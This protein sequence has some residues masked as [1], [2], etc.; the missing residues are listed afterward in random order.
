MKKLISMILVLTLVL[1]YAPSGIF[2]KDAKAESGT[3]VIN[4][5]DDTWA[6]YSTEYRNVI[7]GVKMD[8]E[9]TNIYNRLY[10]IGASSDGDL[11]T[12]VYN[13]SPV[14]M[15]YDL[16]DF[17]DVKI[18]SAKLKLYGRSL[19][20]TA[21][22]NLKMYF[23]KIDNNWSEN[24]LIHGKTPLSPLKGGVPNIDLTGSGD[25]SRIQPDYVSPAFNMAASSDG[26]EL[27]EFDVTELLKKYNL[28]EDTT[29]SFAYIVYPTSY[30]FE[31]VSKDAEETDMHPAL[32]ITTEPIP[33]FEAVSGPEGEIEFDT[34][35]SVSFTNNIDVSSVDASKIQ[36]FEDGEH[37]EVNEEEISAEDDVLTLSTPLNGYCD[38]TIVIDG[39]CDIYG[40][41][42]AS[43]AEFNFSTVGVHTETVYTHNEADSGTEPGILNGAFLRSGTSNLDKTRVTETS[44]VQIMAGGSA[45]YIYCVEV[46][47]TTVDT[48]V[49][50]ASFVYSVKFSTGA[51]Q[52]INV[53][54]FPEFDPETVTYG[55]ISEAINTGEII[56]SNQDLGDCSSGKY[57][58]F[59]L[60]EYV[61][62]KIEDGDKKIYFAIRP[63]VKHT[64][65]FYSNFASSIHRPKAKI[66]FNDDS[67]TGVKETSPAHAETGV[68]ADSQLN[69]TFS[70]PMES[71]TYENFTL[72]NLSDSSVITLGADDVVYDEATQTATVTPPE[73]LD[74][75][76][77]YELSVFG[78]K[79]LK[80]EMMKSKKIKFIT[81]TSLDTGGISFVGDDTID[82]GATVSAS[83]EL[84]N[85]TLSSVKSPTLILALYKGAMMVD[86]EAKTFDEPISPESSQTLDAS[87]NVPKDSDGYD[88]YFAKA[89][90]WDSAEGQRILKEAAIGASAS[91]DYEKGKFFGVASV[92]GGFAN[93]AEKEISVVAKDKD[94]KICF[95]D[96]ITA[97]E[98]GNYNAE[99]GFEK[100]G[101]YE[102]YTMSESAFEKAPATE[103]SDYTSYADYLDI[104]ENINSENKIKIK[105][106]LTK[107][108]D[109]FDFDEINYN[110]EHIADLIAEDIKEYGDFGS[111]CEENI[112]GFYDF[113]KESSFR[114]FKVSEIL[115]DIAD[116]E[117]Y[118]LLTD[119]LTDRENAEYLQINKYMSKYRDN[120][121]KVNKA[122]AGKKFDTLEDFVEAF[123][124]ALSEKDKD[125]EGGASVNKGNS[126]SGMVYTGTTVTEPQQETVPSADTSSQL[127]QT[128]E[129][130][131]LD[132]SSVPWA[133]KEIEFL[134]R[135]GVIS[136]RGE[137]MYA[138]NDNVLREEYVKLIVETV[139]ANTDNVNSIFEDVKKDSWCYP[140]ISA[141]YANKIVNGI[142]DTKFGVGTPITRQDICVMTARTL[143]LVGFT[144]KAEKAASF[145][146][147]NFVSDYAKS[148]VE[149]LSELGIITGTP[150]GKF[151][152]KAN[153]TRAETALIIF[154]TMD[155]IKTN[156]A[157]LYK[158]DTPNTTES[159]TDKEYKYTT[160]TTEQ[161]K[162]DIENV[163]MKKSHPYIHATRETLENIKQSLEAGD[164]EYIAK[165]YAQTK[166]MA[167]EYLN[168]KVTVRTKVSQ[169][170]SNVQPL[171]LSCMTVY[172]VEGDERYLNRC[173]AEF[174]NFKNITDW[175]DSS[176]LNTTMTM[177]SI[178]VCYDWLY[179][180]LTEEQK[181]WALNAIV[182]YGLTM[183]YKV[184][185]NPKALK[186]IKAEYEGINVYC[187]YY[188]YNHAVFNNSHNIVAA[189][190][191][192][193]EMPEFSAFIISN[194][195]YSLECYLDLV[196]DGGFEEP[197]TYYDYC[198]GKY[199]Y[200][201]S[202][203]KSSLGTLYGYEKSPG[204]K[205]T[206]WYGLYIF[207]PMVFG[208]CVPDK[209][210][211]NTDK[212]YILAKESGNE[213]M[214][215]RI[216]DLDQ[217]QG[218]WTLLWYEKGSHKNL[219]D[220]LAV[221]LDRMF[222][223]PNQQVA[224]FRNQ[225]NEGN[226][227]FAGIYTGGVATTHSD[228]VAGLF[229]ID[230]Y[231]E[232]FA[233]AL[234]YGDYDLEGYW[235]NVQNGKRWNYYER[236]TEAGNCMI[237]NPSLD[238]GQ[239]V[240][241]SAYFEKY[242]VSNGA[243]FAIT[244]LE[245]VY[246]REVKSYKR[247]LKIHNNRTQIVVQDEAVMKKPSEIFWSFNTPAEIEIIDQSTAVLSH[248]D[249]RVAVKIYAN[250][251]YELYEMPAEKLPT[252]P[253][254][255]TQR[256]WKEF[257]KLAIRAKGVEQ[258]KLMVEFTPFVSDLQMPET[259]SEWIDLDS[260]VAIEKGADVPKL[261]SLKVNGVD[262]EGFDP[263][264]NYYEI[265]IKDSDAMPQVTA[266]APEGYNFEVI[267]PEKL[268][269]AIDI[270]V[271]EEESENVNYYRIRVISGAGKIDVSSYTKLEPKSIFTPQHDG[272]VAENVLDG[273]LT[274]RWS[275]SSE[276]GETYLDIDLG[277][278]HSLKAIGIAFYSGSKRVSYF[279]ILTSTDG[280]NWK[281]AIEYGR[282][283]GDS[284]EIENFEL[285]VE[286]ARYIRYLGKDNSANKWNSIAE[287]VV[288]GE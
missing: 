242:E 284:E 236:R 249:K 105:S 142:S 70:V 238:V 144:A 28:M 114:H 90:L 119:I 258:L 229:S 6:G 128:E 199:V 277:S 16:S 265:E 176:Q 164:D 190:A 208:D 210:T 205:N 152:P 187:G 42:L 88:M 8:E 221:P 84:S 130:Y 202:A 49:P 81:G 138:P 50:F 207:G 275:A 269:G 203:L 237:I 57:V 23:F 112:S 201:V 244:N 150:D 232:R 73:L 86:Y 240:T 33:D 60:T 204:F 181:Q 125:S 68:G 226:N 272:N 78:A 278:E 247:G 171:I 21:V 141:A 75:F 234:G 286:K 155:Y 253:V 51:G 9:E 14:Y 85:N 65:N 82:E 118:A 231:G 259:I 246:H 151:N 167:D 120:K 140:Y 147:M 170:F 129:N 233:T 59:D 200:A 136:G 179:D 248:G 100:S 89:F 263:E 220:D 160:P 72:K 279:D 47:L 4:P 99:V 252:S 194:A 127:V 92:N 31:A 30:V 153:A 61:N 93:S 48:S 110:I 3:Y 235:D 115:S 18:S 166:A 148:A 282:S 74:E 212:L 54:E 103:V 154:R 135:M 193:Q 213:A 266:E 24:T 211:Y 106:V 69:V 111:Y 217:K 257:R 271:G 283:S 222:Q 197:S 45:Y 43:C 80:D 243:A 108:V 12:K 262:V 10:S 44:R 34:S 225:L 168:T 280:K 288:Y 67:F 37:I 40:N 97:D 227:I 183:S 260:W 1:A 264:T 267:Y 7:Q 104:W 101:D 19:N 182:E 159:E 143:E 133:E 63:T 15:K 255:D 109:V 241:K 285:N 76:T 39:I 251:P 178:A 62:Q 172:Y 17:T 261:N 58:D 188:S 32:E 276:K 122:L 134:Y 228:P 149:Y 132:S 156:G 116:A 113:L 192:A 36:L 29:V 184:Y 124:K 79:S 145:T 64:T 139:E 146:D 91:E 250:V 173:L 22:N 239:D 131:F 175:Y 223:V 195:L 157:T 281:K 214:M 274:T 2:P 5:T 165:E 254:V 268:P 245:P 94:G 35:V 196:K 38:Y 53:I 117:N 96:Q 46:D 163:L 224:L 270:A 218:V 87:L 206:A 26:F 123:E 191:I 25:M 174:E 185:E 219:T 256:E 158:P 180:Y 56:I 198:T 121:K 27:K 162:A 52:K 126:G 230:A 77:A 189:L 287:I 55:E 216:V 13:S 137:R 71:V 66:I 95:I 273:L 215:K 102:V 11:S 41:S 98:K 83:V 161:V 209:T 107:A 186:Q 20:N 169:G 177:V